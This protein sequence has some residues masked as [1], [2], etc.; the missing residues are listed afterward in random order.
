MKSKF[1]GIC[2][3]I[4]II[5]I[6][7]I[8]VSGITLSEKV[9]QPFIARDT[10]YVG[11]SG[12]N[13]YTTIQSAIDDASAGDTIYVYNGIYYENV[14]V[15]KTLDL[16]GESREN[17]IVDGGGGGKVVYLTVDEVSIT[18]FKIRN[19]EYGVYLSSSLNSIVNCESYS[20]TRYGIYFD[21]SSNNNIVNSDSHDNT[22]PSSPSSGM[23]FWLTDSSSYNTFTGCNA[24]NNSG[25]Y[26][27][28]TC[29]Y[30][31]S[32]NSFVDCTSYNNGGS[33]GGYGIRFDLS[34]HNS[35]MNSV[36]YGNIMNICIIQSSYTNVTSCI[37]NNT[38]SIGIFVS[39]YSHYTT[40]MNCS[41]YNNREGILIRACSNSKVIDCIAYDNNE[42]GISI[43][44]NWLGPA[45][46]N[47]II[48]CDSYNNTY[49]IYIFDSAGNN[50]IYHNNF[51]DNFYG[52]YILDSSDNNQ[53][54]HN[55]FIDNTHNGYDSCSNTW[56]DGYPSGGNYWSDY[57]G[58][59]NDGDGIGDTPYH[60]HGGGNKD[61]YPFMNPYG[62][63]EAEP[64]LNC[65]GILSWTDISPGDTVYGTITV[66]NIGEPDSLLDW[67]IDSYPEW[68][69]WS[70]DP[71]SGDDLLAGES[72]DI[73]VEII[74]PDEPKTTFTGDVVILN[75]ENA[76]D[77]CTIDVSL[78]TPVSQEQG[79]QQILRFLQNHPN[80]FS[81]IRQ[82][83]GLEFLVQILLFNFVYI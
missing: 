40:I 35:V 56:D 76:S 33:L 27:G 61:M 10:L 7:I 2:I 80:L 75:S 15:S 20:N 69:N 72:I 11:G 21:S 9:S 45:N 5:I 24:Y 16:V 83:L 34:P 17:V 26:G 49:G 68:G 32:Y 54:Y 46:Y 66:E 36:F 43:Q 12:P 4:L 19:G 82:I 25:M 65:S 71:D 31:S 13:N 6:M 64:D 67:D 60:I 18:N 58:E 48:N 38:N 39:H 37:S 47:N 55:N 1:I 63:E 23:G 42:Y 81:V 22:D 79:Y 30:S 28:I 74:V 41:S 52:I 44:G 29:V 51:N 78:A 70:F 3:C 50:Q 59:D 57:N 73:N 53:I 14:I 62:W 8:P 77:T